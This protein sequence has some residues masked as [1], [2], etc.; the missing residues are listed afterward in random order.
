MYVRREG[1]RAHPYHT[2]GQLW[3]YICKEL[4]IWSLSH[5]S[6][7]FKQIQ[8]LC[9]SERKLEGF[10]LWIVTSFLDILNYISLFC[11]HG[12]S[13]RMGIGMTGLLYVRIS[14]AVLKMYRSNSNYCLQINLYLHQLPSTDCCIFQTSLVTRVAVICSSIAVLAALN[15]HLV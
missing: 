5:L 3:G 12:F 15:E 1:Q 10:V 8:V 4:F 13:C 9:S 2:Q 14:G 11:Y 6:S 7:G